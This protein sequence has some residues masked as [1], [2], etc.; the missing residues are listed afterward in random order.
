MQVQS[1]KRGRGTQPFQ[2][3]IGGA[4]ALFVV[5]GIGGTIYKMLSPGGW[6]SSSMGSHGEA[7][8]IVSAIAII[9]SGAWL[10]REWLGHSARSL[11]TDAVLTLA[12]I[13]GAAYTFELLTS[14]S[15]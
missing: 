11:V 10:I 8:G 1:V 7:S 6:M 13:A 3:L 5:T 9:A 4:I 12:A 15:F 2:T 14:G